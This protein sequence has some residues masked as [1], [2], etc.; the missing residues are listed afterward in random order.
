MRTRDRELL[1]KARQRLQKPPT[2]TPSPS[3]DHKPLA[4][5]LIF[6]WLLHKLFSG[7]S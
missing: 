7:G 1:A 6:W 3:A 4:I 2:P 5:K